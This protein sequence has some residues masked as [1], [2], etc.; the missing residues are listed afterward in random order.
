MKRAWMVAAAAA[1][2]STHAIAA[3]VTIERASG[4]FSG[5]G[6]EFQVIGSGAGLLGGPAS[7]NIVGAPANSFQTFCIEL[8]EQVS[9]GSSYASQVN[10]QVISGTATP[11]QGVLNSVSN[12]VPGGTVT[13]GGGRS[14]LS[15]ATVW[16]YER[17]RRGDLA[18]YTY[19]TGS[20]R[21]EN[22][23]DLQIAFWYFQNQIEF[24]AGYNPLSNSFISLINSE[25]G[26]IADG[27]ASHQGNTQVRVLNLGTGAGANP[28]RN[29]DMLTLI[30]LPTGGG[31][32]AAGLFG[33]AAV[34]RR[35]A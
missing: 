35:R 34:R 5:A 15:A 7:A 8:G 26:S 13:F 10:T 33:I 30:P 24:D 27:R 4:T 2:V 18:G 25:L 23:R 21:S 3:T 11:S 22:A 1:C 9:V 31:L 20:T 16:L 14:D 28:W 12:M 6:G 29:Q 19:D 17:F 32:A